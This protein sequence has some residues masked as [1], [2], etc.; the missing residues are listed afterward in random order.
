MPH[1]LTPHKA[2]KMLRHGEV[3]GQPL[4]K[5]Q[6]GLFGLIRGGGTPTQVRTRIGKPRHA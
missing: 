4:T 3:R 2:G 1:G 6:K 5:R